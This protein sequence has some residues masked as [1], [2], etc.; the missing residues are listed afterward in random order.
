MAIQIDSYLCDGINTVFQTTK[1]Y[2]PTTLTAKMVDTLNVETAVLLTELGENFI[3][4][5]ITVPDTYTLVVTYTVLGTLPNDN[6]IEFDILARLNALENAIKD[7]HKIQEA[8]R[9]AINN[10]VNITAFQAWIRLVEK[11]LGI[12]LINNNLGEISTEL[13]KP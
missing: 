12:K 7:L 13:Y 4:T 8:Q 1:K 5:N 9:E 2:S 11:K 3:Q 10:R 6:Q